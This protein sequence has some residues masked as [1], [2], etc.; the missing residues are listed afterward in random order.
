MGSLF[1]RLSTGD[2][3]E[4]GISPNGKFVSPDQVNKGSN[5]VT[6][7]GSLAMNNPIG[8]VWPDYVQDDNLTITIDG[9]AIPG[10]TDSVRITANGDTIT[11]DPAY[12]WVNMANDEISNT[13]GA[14][15]E[16]IFFAKFL[17]YD[18]QGNANAGTIL[19]T[20]KII[21]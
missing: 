17:N 14:V 6:F 16:L 4:P 15:N 9:D 20:C 19:Y 1:R 21:V 7:N 5:R 18:N 12:T 8:T 13:D 2:V 3:I 10:G 11:L